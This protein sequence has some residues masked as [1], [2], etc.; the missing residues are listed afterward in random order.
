MGEKGLTAQNR[1]AGAD[2]GMIITKNLLGPRSS[3][4]GSCSVMLIHSIVLPLL[5]EICRTLPEASN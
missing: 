2:T 5:P 1:G 4:R 3:S